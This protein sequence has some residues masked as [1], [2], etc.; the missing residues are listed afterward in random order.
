MAEGNGVIGFSGDEGYLLRWL[1]EG[2][3]EKERKEK[4][5][6]NNKHGVPDFHLHEFEFVVCWR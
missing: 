4:C 5:N 6:S 1:L 2:K 3:R